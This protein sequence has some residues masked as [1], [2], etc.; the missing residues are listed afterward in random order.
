MKNRTA[1]TVETEDKH[2]IHFDLYQNGQ[3][4]VI[5]IA[6]GFFNS[7]GAVLL[8]EL[9]R[10]LADRY[11]VIIMDFRGHGKSQ[12]LFHWTSKEYLDLGAVLRYARTSY[13]RVGVVGFSLGAATSLIVASQS[14]L[15]DSLIAVSAPTEFGK[16]DYHFWE[17]DIENDVFYNLAGEGRFG[18]GVRP[19]PFWL[20]KGKP[21]QQ[22]A[23]VTCPVFYIHGAS[24]WLI[25]PRHSEELYKNT[26]G[27]KRLAIIK[28]GPHAEYLIRKNKTETIALIRDWFG[29]TLKAAQSG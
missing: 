24:D 12:G 10:E 11:D 9:G 25:K 3:R 15:I 20:K 28:N 23:K 26:P 13:S 21:I 29:S 22:V 19:G 6:H 27:A 18:K 2:R 7:K 17:L 14:R 4:E 1:K 5:V 16:I 8:Q